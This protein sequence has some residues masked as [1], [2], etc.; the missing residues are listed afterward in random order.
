MFLDFRVEEHLSARVVKSN[1]LL[2]LLDQG[3]LEVTLHLLF[4]AL[5]ILL[6]T[7]Y[8]EHCGISFIFDYAE[9]KQLFHAEAG[10]LK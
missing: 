5:D 10:G 2:K 8:K 1:L 9:R 7:S 3:S 4:P 6:M